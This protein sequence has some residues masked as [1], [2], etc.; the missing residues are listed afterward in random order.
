MLR[1]RIIPCLLLSNKGLVKTTN[2]GDPR[3]VGDPL[4]AVKIFNEKAV[5]ELMFLDIDASRESREP[6]F[7]LIRR[8]AVECRM[9]LSYGGGVTSAEQAQKIIQLGVEK[10]AISSAAIANESLITDI[11]N[12]IGRQSVCVVIDVRK[13]PR[14]Q[15]Y[16]VFDL[17][18]TRFL[19]VD[20]L[21]FAQRAQDLGAGEIA[22]NSIDRDGTMTGYDF[23]LAKAFR[24]I[25]DAPLTIL[26]GA[27]STQHFQ[28]LIDAIGVCGAAAGSFFVFR[29]KFRAV[30]ISYARPDRLN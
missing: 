5:D 6:N 23:D 21:A 29:G 22:I 16:E 27:G 30:L 8:I 13:N 20:P 26:G 18:G 1:S 3:Y 19:D 15:S 17:N 7:D 11:A 14:T 25:T 12:A 28:Q 9:P 4:N 10:V 2:F 24:E